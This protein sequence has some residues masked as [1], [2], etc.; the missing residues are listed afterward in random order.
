MPKCQILGLTVSLFVSLE[1]W[2]IKRII[3][4]FSS[5]LYDVKVPDGRHSFM[6]EMMFL[7]SAFLKIESE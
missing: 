3:T 7:E 4:Q 1:Q 6:N 2:V 5:L